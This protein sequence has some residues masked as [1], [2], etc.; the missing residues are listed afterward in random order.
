MIAF[1]TTIGFMAS[2]KLLAKGGVQVVIFLIAATA[3]VILQDVVG[4]SLAKVFGLPPLFGLAAGSIPLTG[5]HGTSG[6]FGPLLEQAGATGATA[7]AIASATYGLVAGSLIGGPI[8]KRLMT[9]HNLKP[10]E[11]N[12]SNNRLVKSSDF[13]EEMKKKDFKR[14]IKS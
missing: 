8:G 12:N 5:G 14:L 4:I 1:F 11:E 10:S 9:K 6:A 7:V 2:F 13:K 3:L